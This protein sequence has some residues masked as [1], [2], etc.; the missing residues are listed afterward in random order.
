MEH[1]GTFWGVIAWMIV[2]GVAGSVAIRRRYLQHD[3]D[4]SNTTFV[5]AMLGAA[6]GPVGLVPL[7]LKTPELTNRLIVLP[8]IGA[9][10][11]VAAAFA[12]ADPRQQLRRQ[13]LVRRLAESRTGS[14]S[15][16]STASWPSAS[17]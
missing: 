1:P 8:A 3:L 14:S 5:G 16:S 11:L 9:V 15:A 7:W 6:T 10:V 17:P 2:W 13:R 12:F 4:T